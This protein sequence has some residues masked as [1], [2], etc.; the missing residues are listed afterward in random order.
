MS[1]SF[2]TKYVGVMYT[3]TE[4]IRKNLS[5]IYASHIKNADDCEII[6][7]SIITS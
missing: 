1:D 4:K 5:R 3:V 6:E 7:N 2:R